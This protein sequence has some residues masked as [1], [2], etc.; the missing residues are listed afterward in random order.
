MPASRSLKRYGWLQGFPEETGTASRPS[1]RGTFTHDAIIP[2]RT[3]GESAL[4][5]FLSWKVRQKAA[6]GS[7]GRSPGATRPSE[8]YRAT[9]WSWA[10]V[11][12]PVRYKWRKHSSPGLLAAAEEVHLDCATA[13]QMGRLKGGWL[14]LRAL[15][16][17]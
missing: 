14:W 6:T 1:A 15:A 3:G 4:K 17:S 16:V 13:D 12:S 8:V 7:V 2:R 5:G 9:S 11:D 10:S